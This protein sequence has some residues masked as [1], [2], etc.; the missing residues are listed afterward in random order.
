LCV[1]TGGCCSKAFLPANLFAPWGTLDGL[2]KRNEC[3]KEGQITIFE[4]NLAD[5]IK[6][7]S[8]SISMLS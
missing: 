2:D 4:E 5:I 3:Q 1:Y 7:F 6:T 8:L